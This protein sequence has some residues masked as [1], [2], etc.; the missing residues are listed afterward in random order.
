MA[1]HV[2][3]ELAWVSFENEVLK[4]QLQLGKQYCVA[5]NQEKGKIAMNK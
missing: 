4:Y 5:A 2:S 1:T 3:W